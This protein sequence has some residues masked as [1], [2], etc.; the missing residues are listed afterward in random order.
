MGKV[1]KAQ[2]NIWIKNE[3]GKKEKEIED[4][5][6]ILTDIYVDLRILYSMKEKENR[7]EGK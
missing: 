6:N 5:R 2:R 4:I 7:R 3:I 1:N